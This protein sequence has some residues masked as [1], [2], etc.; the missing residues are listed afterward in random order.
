MLHY[1]ARMKCAALHAYS[2]LY[3]YIYCNYNDCVSPTCT[4]AFC[5]LAFQAESTTTSK[6]DALTPAKHKALADEEYDVAMG[7][8]ALIG[9][10]KVGHTK[11]GRAACVVLGV[12][13][14]SDPT[15]HVQALC[16]SK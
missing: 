6:I 12:A 11:S 1:F 9:N 10:L 4:R 16:M 14:P 5:P 2:T 15:Q 8:T 13:Q 7:I 3:V